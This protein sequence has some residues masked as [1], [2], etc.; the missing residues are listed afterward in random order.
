GCRT[1]KSARGWA[2]PRRRSRLTSRR[3]SRR[4]TSSIARRRHTPCVQPTWSSPWPWLEPEN[5]RQD[6]EAPRRAKKNQKFNFQILIS[7]SSLFD[8]SSLGSWRLG[9]RN[10]FEPAGRFAVHCGG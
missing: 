8:F 1:R 4:S 6:A 2:L 7:R 9:E 5:S 10:L 3:S